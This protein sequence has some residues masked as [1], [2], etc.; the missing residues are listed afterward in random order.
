MAFG[1][2]DPNSFHAAL[3]ELHVVHGCTLK[4]TSREWAY[5]LDQVFGENG[6][7]TVALIYTLAK[8]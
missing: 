2:S 5:L 6:D 3:L 4:H 1:M 7:P 8:S